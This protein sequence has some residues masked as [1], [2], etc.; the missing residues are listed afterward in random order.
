VLLDVLLRV[1]ARDAISRIDTC[2][3]PTAHIL[4]LAGPKSAL[5]SRV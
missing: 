5:L 2:G 4:I 3:T 1:I